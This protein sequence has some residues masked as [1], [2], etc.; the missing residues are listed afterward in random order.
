MRHPKDNL[1]Q[2]P[3]CPDNS[4][5]RFGRQRPMPSALTM[6]SEIDRRPLRVPLNEA[7]LRLARALARQAARE[8]YERT[9]RTEQDR[10]ETSG[11]LCTIFNGP[12]E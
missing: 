8:D 1:V 9:R 7:I 3:P 10:Q 12:A 5:R 4:V 2:K 11:Y 6:R